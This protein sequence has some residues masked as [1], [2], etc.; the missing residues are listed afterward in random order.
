MTVTFVQI[1]EWHVMQVSVG[2]SP[3]YAEV[4]T[5]VWQYRQSTPSSFTWCLWLNGIG[6]AGAIR[7]Q[8]VQGPRST[9]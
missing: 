4:S 9:M 6:W 5:L 7:T 3:A 1:C 2:G 8:V